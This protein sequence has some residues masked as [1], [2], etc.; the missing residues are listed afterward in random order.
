[1]YSLCIPTMDRFDKFLNENL[2][3]YIENPYIDEIII[4]DENGND[5]RKIESTF[6]SDKL[7]LFINSQ[8]LG[9]FFNKLNCCKRAKNIW[10]AII[11][12]DNFADVDYFE[13]A[14]AYIQTNNLHK[15][16]PVILSPDFAKP[17]FDFKH[18]DGFIYKKETFKE[19]I[20]R[21]KANPNKGTSSDV[22]MN[23]G[24]YIINQFLINHIDIRDE[25][26]HIIHSS[27][28]DVIYFNVLLWEQFDTELHIV[29]GLEYN[30]EVHQGSVYVQTHNLTRPFVD[31]V[32]SRYY[33]LTKK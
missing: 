15:L 28:C 20:E 22:L 14:S 21:E 30:H 13:T 16:C 1:M 29:S 7:K 31:Y 23:T 8:R 27:A 26:Q 25:L 5:V 9:P 11:D 32:H 10:I 19:N 12:S 24:N 33:E 18:L 17:T 4:C 6:T 2:K 3:K